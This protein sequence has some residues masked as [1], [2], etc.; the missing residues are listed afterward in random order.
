MRGKFIGGH[1]ANLQSGNG[2]V[3]SYAAREVDQARVS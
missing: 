3:A 2:A 1:Q